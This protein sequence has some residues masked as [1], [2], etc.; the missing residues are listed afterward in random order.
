MF[1]ATLGRALLDFAVGLWLLVT[2]SVF[3]L[4]LVERFVPFGAA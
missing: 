3:G 1:A 2:V 4:C